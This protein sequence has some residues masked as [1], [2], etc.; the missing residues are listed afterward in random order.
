MYKP[1]PTD[2]KF[3]EREKAV[4]SFWK[5]RKIF[6]KSTSNR[7]GAPEFTFYDGPPTANGSRTSVT[8]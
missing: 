6:E 7:E 5:D 2:M 3:V 4:L 1:V 8:S